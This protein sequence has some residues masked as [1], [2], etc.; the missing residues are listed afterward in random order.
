MERT[1]LKIAR[2]SLISVIGLSLI[3]TVLAAVYGCFAFIPQHQ[4]A[5]EISIKYGN[6]TEDR[7][8][9]QSQ[10]EAAPP[11]ATSADVGKFLSNCE[12]LAS[13][14]D[15]V[16]SQIGWEARRQTTYDPATMQFVNKSA[17]DFDESINRNPFCGRIQNMLNEQNAKLAPY[18]TGIDLTDAYFNNFNA[19]LDAVLANVQK[20]KALPPD[21]PN[22]HYAMTTITWFNTQ[23]EKSVDSTRDKAME[24]EEKNALGKTHAVMAFYFAASAFGFFF[25]CCL[26]L[27][28][29]RIE[30]NT[31]E[32]AQ[33]ARS[34]SEKQ[35]R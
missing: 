4:Q 19:Y 5:P 14:L 20:E 2:F 32:L 11:T 34:L 33:I 15:K 13:R 3:V 28:F 30:V 23:F 27:V 21:N 17:I 12:G 8:P 16:S 18:F 22:R 25:A 35:D 26:I 24:T 6:L 31:R 1:F 9:S 29:I 7:T 10:N